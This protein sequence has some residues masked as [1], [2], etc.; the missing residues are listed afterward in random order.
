MKSIKITVTDCLASVTET[1]SVVSGTVGLPV[2]FSFDD[3][4]AGLN[5][6]AVFRANGKTMDVLNVTSFATVPWELLKTPGCRL[7]AGAYGTNPDGSLQIPTV[8]ADL[9]VIQPGADPS[10]DESAD[11]TLPVWEQAREGAVLYTPQKKTEDEKTQACKN[12]GAI[13]KAADGSLDMEGCGIGNLADGNSDTDAAT[14]GQVK[15]LAG[16]AVKTVNGAA[17]DENGNVEIETGGSADSADNYAVVVEEHTGR[18]VLK[19]AEETEQV[20]EYLGLGQTSVVDGKVVFT[21]KTENDTAGGVRI[22]YKLKANP[23]DIIKIQ[24]TAYWT[25]SQYA[26]EPACCMDD[27]ALVKAPGFV[28]REGGI[29]YQIPKNYTGTTLV[30]LGLR[31]PTKTYNAPKTW[32]VIDNDFE[33]AFYVSRSGMLSGNTLHE[34]HYVVIGADG[35]LCVSPKSSFDNEDVQ[36]KTPW[37][38][39]AHRGYPNGVR[40]NT[41]PA[42]YEALMD[43]CTMCEVDVQLTSDNV[44]VLCHDDNITGTIDGVSTTLTVETSTY[45]E[46]SS[47]VLT[48]DTKYGD[49]KIAKLED[50]LK[51]ARHYNMKLMIDIKSD[52]S[53]YITA[54]VSMVKKYNMS[55]NVLYFPINTP[56]LAQRLVTLDKDA[57]V[58]LYY[59]TEETRL[60]KIDGIE[61]EPSN[62]VI[63]CTQ[64]QTTDEAVAYIREKKYGLWCWGINSYNSSVFQYCPDYVEYTTG[65]NVTS[66]TFN[67][68]NSV[69]FW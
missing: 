30:L 38:N 60:E 17:P 25:E 26:Y 1:L 61:T 35:E 67:Y 54:V 12:I 4:W 47:L 23:G 15:K 51:L 7:W 31:S 5:K 6:T 3:A 63:A 68:F 10:G 52:I 59:T 58:I 56:A 28:T 19:N 64:A 62:I 33:K 43:G 13:K 36:I 9:G 32:G 2:E 27:Y 16:G 45:A 24:P 20:V 46:L 34:G 22:Y 11:P 39:V 65:T 18:V 44:L 57:T 66:L 50:A 69:K 55:K 14:V 53:D 41:I 40:E 42:L 37:I 49:V 21:P 29:S 48:P 8:W